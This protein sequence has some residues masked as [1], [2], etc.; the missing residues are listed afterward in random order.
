MME[1]M[2]KIRTKSFYNC[3]GNKEDLSDMINLFIE[4]TH[5]CQLLDI[6]HGGFYEDQEVA[7]IKY[8][9]KE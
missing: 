7:I 5:N 2:N 9:I 1:I 4:K 8:M 6:I 3:I